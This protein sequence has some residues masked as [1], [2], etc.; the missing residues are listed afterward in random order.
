MATDWRRLERVLGNL[1]DNARL[2]ADGREVEIEAR[3]KPDADGRDELLLSVADR[4]PGV[5][6]AE[7]PHLFERFRKSDPSRHLGG[8]GLGLAIATSCP[9][10]GPSRPAPTRRGMRF[11]CGSL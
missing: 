10:S 4:G 2:H 6:A 3:L 9:P 11:E 8:S 1:L 7:L 5:P